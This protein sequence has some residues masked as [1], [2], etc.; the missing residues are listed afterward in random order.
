MKDV[1]MTVMEDKPDG[2]VESDTVWDVI[3]KLPEVKQ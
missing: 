3:E 1:Q 2:G